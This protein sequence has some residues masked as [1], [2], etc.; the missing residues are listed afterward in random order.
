MALI[1]RIYYRSDGSV[2]IMLLPKDSN[3]L[4][5]VTEVW[6]SQPDIK[7]F[8]DLT[9][10]EFNA[11]YPKDAT[12]KPDRSQRDKFRRHPSGRGFHVDPLVKTKKEERLS[13]INAA[14]T[15]PELKQLLREMIDG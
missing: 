8:D 1:H 6:N 7:G 14:N 10:V 11:M 2:T 5:R 4:A 12:G 3:E 13:R 15:I 9:E